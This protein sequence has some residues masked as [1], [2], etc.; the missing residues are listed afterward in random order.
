M[1]NMKP[2]FRYT[3]IT[4]PGKKKEEIMRVAQENLY[5]FKRINERTSVYNVDKWNR[6][7]SLSQY[8]KKNLCQYQSI[9]FSRTQRRGSCIN[10]FAA[11]Q[12]KRMKRTFSKTHYSG[13]LNN[14]KFKKKF[15]DY[16]YRDL[17][18]AGKNR[19]QIGDN[20]AAQNFT[21]MFANGDKLKVEK[22]EEKQFENKKEEE[23][24]KNDNNQIKNENRNENKN[25]NIIENKNEIEKEQNIKNNNKNEKELI[26]EKNKIPE[27]NK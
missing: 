11:M 25:E 18:M 4:M 16:S 9:D 20:R 12:K 26:E 23:D 15:E 3:K 22:E 5:M 19:S 14:S 24:K 27:E 10:V 2:V 7:Y 17:Q 6:D 21:K 8:Y 13:I 1:K